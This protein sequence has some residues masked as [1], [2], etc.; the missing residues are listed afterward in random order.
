MWPET[1]TDRFPRRARGGNNVSTRY[2]A[3]GAGDVNRICELRR[4]RRALLAES[5]M[6]SGSEH[7]RLAP[8]IA[9][10]YQPLPGGGRR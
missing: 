10:N 3:Y 7:D 9:R 4:Q 6:A 1:G 8:V 2:T 5:V